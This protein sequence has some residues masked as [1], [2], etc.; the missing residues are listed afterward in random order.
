[1]LGCYEQLAAAHPKDAERF[2]NLAFQC[3][4]A[5]EFEQARQAA[6]QGLQLAPDKAWIAGNLA[7]ALMFL[8]RTNEAVALHRRYLNVRDI[9]N[10]LSWKQAALDD[11]ETFRTLGLNEPPGIE[12]ALSTIEK[13]LEPAR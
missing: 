9:G 10:G 5:G 13:L 7:H 12:N 6:E 2:G 8:K 4:L 3:L 11:F 1:L